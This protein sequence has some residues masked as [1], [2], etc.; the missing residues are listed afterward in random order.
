VQCLYLLGCL[1]PEDGAR[2][3]LRNVD[4]DITGYITS[5]HKPSATHFSESP[6]EGGN[7]SDSGVKR[8]VRVAGVVTSEAKKGYKSGC[9]DGYT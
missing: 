8:E 5:R 7:F 3:L 2:S 1:Y 9:I 4:N 6:R